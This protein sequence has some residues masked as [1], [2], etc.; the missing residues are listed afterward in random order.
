MAQVDSHLSTGLPGLDRV[1]KGLI[2]GDNIVWQVDSVEGYRPFVEPHCRWVRESGQRLIYF[3][4]ARHGPL[5]GADVGATV[6][7]LDPQ[8]GF[9]AFITGIHRTIEQNGRG[10]YKINVVQCRPLQV[11]Q[12]EAV[13]EPPADLDPEDR[14]LEARGAVIGQSRVT[15][16]DRLI[17]VVP[18]VYA[19]LPIG[20]RY[21]LARLIGRLAHLDEDDAA[22]TVMLVG[23]G[24]WGTT[25]P[26]LG[27]PVSFADI[28]AVSALCEVVAMG[29]KVAPDVSLGTHFLNELIEMDILYLALFPKQEG[30]RLNAAF[31]AGAPNRL[32]ALVP[33]AA[34]WADAVRVIEP[35]HLPDTRGLVLHADTLKQQ[36]LC[37]RERDA[38]D[39]A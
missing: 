19:D 1:L 36:V 18:E 10:G 28:N 11:Q 9:E 39:K 7:E 6:C 27:V 34:E 16:L 5:I 2:P 37:Y 21:G 13:A 14:V 30:N 29:E 24:R 4:F 15:R 12:S 3:R 33:D 17:Y 25:T 32:T 20:R 8:D 23:P 26:S 22:R 35:D 31:L 38:A